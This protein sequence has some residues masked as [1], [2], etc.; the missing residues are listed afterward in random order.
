MKINLRVKQQRYT[1]NRSKI[2][3]GVLPNIQ[4]SIIFIERGKNQLTIGKNNFMNSG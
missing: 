4:P 1:M 3:R 2:K